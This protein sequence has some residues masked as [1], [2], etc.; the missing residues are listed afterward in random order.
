MNIDNMKMFLIISL[1]A[2]ILMSL[3]FF[4][5][6]VSLVFF[7]KGDLVRLNLKSALLRALAIAI[8]FGVAG[9]VKHKRK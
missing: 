2:L 4:I 1:K 6:E 3:P 9:A 7:I 8:F 5:I